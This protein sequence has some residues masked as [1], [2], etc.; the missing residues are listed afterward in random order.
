MGLFKGGK[1]KN[2]GATYANMENGGE[3][4]Q[5]TLVEEYGLE[6]NKK[7]PNNGGGTLSSILPTTTGHPESGLVFIT[8]HP[9]FVPQCP[10]CQTV[11]AKT[12][13]RTAPGILTIAVSAALLLGIGYFLGMWLIALCVC[14]IPFCMD[15]GK[16]TTHFCMVCS[17]ELGTIGPC[18]DCCSQNRA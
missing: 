18:T 1:D 8:R 12:R 5:A 13:I 3:P 16:S 17:R 2:D 14:T 10:F 4:I 7:K 6:D 11:N 9:T 15:V